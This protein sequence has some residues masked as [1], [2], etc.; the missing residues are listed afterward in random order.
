METQNRFD[1]LLTILRSQEVIYEQLEQLREEDPAKE[2]AM[3]EGKHAKTKTTK[4]R[5]E[6]AGCI[7]CEDPKQRKK[8]TLLL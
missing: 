3:F 4:L 8:K 7:I 5:S 1:N 6:P 2:M